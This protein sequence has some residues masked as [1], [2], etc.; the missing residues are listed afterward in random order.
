MT[1]TIDFYE[2]NAD[3]FFESTVGVEAQDLH[4]AFL[5]Y[6]PQNATILDAGC[7]SGR[8]TLA[9]LRQGYRVFAFDGSECMAKRAADLTGLPVQTSLF[10]DYTAGQL[11]D[12]IWACASLLHVPVEQLAVTFSHLSKFLKNEGVFY[13]SFK[14]GSGEVVRK[15]RHFTNLDEPGLE[16]I[17][18]TTDLEMAKSWITTDL[19]PGRENEHWLNAILKKASLKKA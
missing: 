12:G 8:D 11:F 7:G 14:L 15:G 16:A 5:A 9:F 18:T 4:Q 1:Q 3:S 19:R 6:L 17:L 13:C 2:Q 10:L